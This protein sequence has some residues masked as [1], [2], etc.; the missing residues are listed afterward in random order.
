MG[1]MQMVRRDGGPIWVNLSLRHFSADRG[2]RKGL[3]FKGSDLSDRRL[4]EQYRVGSGNELQDI[5]ESMED[6]IAVCDP[7]GTILMCNKAHCD[8]L[9]YR[10]EDI[11]GMKQPYP[12]IEQ[13]DRQKRRFEMKNLLRRGTFK[14]YTLVWHRKDGSSLVVSEALSL[15]K[16][17]AGAVKGYVVTSRNITDVQYVDELRRTNDRMQRLIVDVQRKAERLNTLE[18]VNR[19]VLEGASVT[20]IFKSVV[21]GVGRIVDHDLAGIYVYDKGRDCLYPHTVSRVTPYSRKLSKF[22]L[23]IGQGIIGTAASSGKPV[24]VNNAQRD[25]RSRY[26]ENMKPELEHFIAV[27]LK[28]RNSIFGVLVVARNENPEFVEEEALI[29]NSF[30]NATMVALEHARLSLELNSIH[31]R[32]STLV[33]HFKGDKDNFRKGMNGKGRQK[34]IGE[35]FDGWPVSGQNGSKRHS[36]LRGKT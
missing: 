6:A 32:I 16:N 29:V 15:L 35:M 5:L 23:P 33:S 19:L 17:S 28:G 21:H 25:P 34:A 11:V 14:N 22:P 7:H 12:W 26:P 31:D 30:A 20:K 36:S 2:R 27:P 1:E 24:I 9:Q 8:M 4:L 3:V 10:R 13:H 18:A